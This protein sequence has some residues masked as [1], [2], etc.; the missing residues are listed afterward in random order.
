MFPGFGLKRVPNGP[1][2][3][4]KDH[5]AKRL[6]KTIKKCVTDPDTEV[7]FDED[8]DLA[9]PF[10]SALVMVSFFGEPTH[11][12]YYAQLLREVDERQSMRVYARLNELNASEPLTR[13]VM[14]ADAIYA[15][16]DICV[17]PFVSKHV[18]QSFLRFC[19]FAASRDSLLQ[20]EFGGQTAMGG[21]QQSLTR[22]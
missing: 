1:T 11:I 7:E 18:S 22:N 6:L 4:L 5:N 8:G 16:A 12:R 10:L 14:S 21:I 2:T 19:E 3:V 17:L 20:A 9:V 15:I 13:L